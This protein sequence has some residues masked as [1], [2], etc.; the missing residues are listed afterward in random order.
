MCILI[1]M[2]RKFFFALVFFALFLAKPTN[3]FAVACSVSVSSDPLNT[4]GSGILTFTIKNTTEDGTGINYLKFTTPSN[5]FTIT[6]TNGDYVT[7]AT[8]NEAG[9]ED[10]VTLSGL[11]A[12]EEKQ[13][14]IGVSVGSSA[15]ASAS[16]TVQAANSETGEGAVNCEGSTGVSIISAGQAVINISNVTASITSVTSSITWTTSVNTTGQVD[17]GPTDQY[18]ST[19]T[20][21]NL[22]TSHSVSLSGLLANTAYHFRVSSTDENGNVAQIVDN[23]FTTAVAGTITTTTTTAV[24][25]ASTTSRAIPTPKPLKDTVAPV[26]S[27]DTEFEKPFLEAPKITGTSSDR[28]AINVGVVSVEYSI[29]D[30]KNWLPVDEGTTKFEFTPTIFEDGNYKIKV[31]AKDKTG[32]TGYSSTKTMIIDRL[33]PQVGGVLFSIGPQVSMPAKD[34]SIFSLKSLNQKVTL[35][36]VGG[37]TTIDIVASTK[38]FS[39]IK[40]SDSGLWSGVLSFDEPGTYELTA[41]AVDGA[42]NR[43]ER[44]LNTITVL[45]SGKIVSGNSLVTSGTVT[46][47]YFDNQTQRFVIWDGSPYSQENPQKITKN[48]EYG[49]FA[50]SGKYYLEVRSFGFKI[51]RT[52]IFNL[53]IG[54]PITAQLNL[55]KS[56]GLHF[57][58]FAFPLPDFSVSTQSIIVK[59]PVASSR[60]EAGTNVVGKELPNVDL[61]LNAKKISTMSLMGKPA[62]FTFLSIWSPYGAEQLK[63]LSELSENSQI[64]TV[65]IISQESSTFTSVF[66][67]RGDYSFPIY[68]DPDG[69]LVKPLDL[70]FLPTNVFV[71][72]KGIV[73]KVK[74]GILTK[75]ELLENMIN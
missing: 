47:W 15:V 7:G 30:G 20:D 10:E 61:F 13:Y 5:N 1:N 56:F 16:W 62:V 52:E 36:A 66:S 8:I 34:G 46:L 35:S 2:G 74:V 14:F 63:S 3:A 22:S 21:T 17:Y 9:T 38:T 49:F 51:L 69:L 44:K 57:G 27:I 53:D 39:L 48:G 25:T 12:F 64:N 42:E 4:G 28:G 58:S 75:D 50:P 72:R 11:G 6:S 43:T 19:A 24:T 18:G 73:R 68:S 37:P 29:D 45:D 40:N 67:K 60:T 33:P 41:K 32:N 70:S 65:P 59:S 71:D 23:S 54:T 26:I 55:E 31:R